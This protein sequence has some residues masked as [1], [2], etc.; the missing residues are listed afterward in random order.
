MTLK[1]DNEE[2]EI[3]HSYENEEWESVSS[4]SEISKYK[5]AA[6]STFKKDKRVNTRMS[7]RDLELLQERALIEGLPY[8]TLM[9]SVL[10]KYVMNRLSEKA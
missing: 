3:L 5:A 7:E 4:P 8:Q 6:K 2:K 10:H 1:L 9:S